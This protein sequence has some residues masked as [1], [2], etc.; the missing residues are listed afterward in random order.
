MVKRVGIGDMI[1][2]TYN[3]I[4]QNDFVILCTHLSSRV[5]HKIRNNQLIKQ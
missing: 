5:M 2:C 3:Q 4:T 1:T